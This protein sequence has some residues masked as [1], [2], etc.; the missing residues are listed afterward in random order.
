MSAY[1]IVEIDVSD[2]EK[3]EQYKKLAFTSVTVH[4][5]KYIVRGGSSDVFEGEWSPKRIVVLEFESM[6]KARAWYHS[7]DYQDAKQI[8][9]QASIANMICVEGTV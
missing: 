4:G 8:R 6:A 7:E 1:V 9:L 2:P 5:G 3:Y